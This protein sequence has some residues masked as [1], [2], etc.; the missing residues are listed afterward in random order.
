[1]AHGSDDQ[2]GVDDAVVD[3]AKPREANLERLEMLRTFFFQGTRLVQD[4]GKYWL[5]ELSPR[6]G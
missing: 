3:D 1:M 6:P 5:I 4:G 2:A